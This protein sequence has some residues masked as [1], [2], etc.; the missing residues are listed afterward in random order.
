MKY[1]FPILFSLFCIAS[2]KTT[3]STQA[4]NDPPAEQI[5]IIQDSVI[6]GKV[7]VGDVCPLYIEAFEG[8]NRLILYPVNLEE[9]L[10][11]NGAMIRFSYT[12]SRAKQPG[13][14]AVDKVVSLSNVEQLR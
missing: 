7:R 14:C 3:K 8:E 12:L 10:Q 5:E 2:C 13:T 9:Y 4:L 1:L 11:V 6:V